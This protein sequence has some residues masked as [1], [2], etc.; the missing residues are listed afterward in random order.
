MYLGATET[1][2]LSVS[3][4]SVCLL[5]VVSHPPAPV[6]RSTPGHVHGEGHRALRSQAWR[7]L[8]HFA[9]V[10]GL[11]CHRVLLSAR[12]AGAQNIT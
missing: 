3:T 5:F 9:H 4:Q 8:G 2:S 1:P 6:S 7:G 11:V 12:E 10:H